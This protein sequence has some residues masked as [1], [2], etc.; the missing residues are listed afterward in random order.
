MPPGAAGDPNFDREDS[1]EDDRQNRAFK[2]KEQLNNTPQVETYVEIKVQYHEKYTILQTTNVDEGTMPRW[3][4]I[5]DF[6]LQSQNS[7]GFTQEELMSSKTMIIATLFDKQTYQSLREGERVILEEHRY[8]GSISI[9]LITLLL[10]GGKTDFNFRLERPVCLPNYRVLDDEIYFM[11]AD[12]LEKQRKME[13]EQPPTY[14]NLS[15]T[16]E[17]NIE[18]QKENPLFAYPGHEE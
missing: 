1:L 13:N 6:P 17:P 5:L 15:I 2:T 14:L 12:Q 10:N 11:K 18:L 16:I 7:E 3:N 8:L 4:E 9:P